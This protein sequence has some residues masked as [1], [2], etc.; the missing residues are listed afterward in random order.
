MNKV[1]AASNKF[2][3][4]V[5]V[6][7]AVFLFFY[8]TDNSEQT[9]QGVINAFPDG[10]DAKNY[11]L[12]AEMTAKTVRAGLFNT[13]RYAIDKMYWPNGGYSTLKDCVVMKDT[14]SLCITLDGDRYL[15]EVVTPP[16][17]GQYSDN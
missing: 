6:I 13:E 7:F 10:A 17:R 2:L 9:G 12:N 16:Q 5:I 1:I 4:L 14:Q 8:Y 15:I 11:R 3:P